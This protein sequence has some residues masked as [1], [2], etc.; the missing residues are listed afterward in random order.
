MK[1]LALITILSTTVALVCAQVTLDPNTGHYVCPAN[2][3]PVPLAFCAGE[4][5]A[6]NIIIRCDGLVGQ[7]GNCN[8]NLAGIPPVGVKLFAPCYQSSTVAGDAACS[9]DGI[10][11]P[12]S[13]TPF[14]IGSK[15]NTTT[16]SFAVV[17]SS[18]ISISISS[19]QTSEAVALSTGQI[20]TVLTNQRGTLSTPCTKYPLKSTKT[21]IPP[22]PTKKN[23][24]SSYV[25]AQFSHDVAKH[26]PNHKTKSKHILTPVSVTSGAQPSYDPEA[27]PTVP[28]IVAVERDYSRP[29]LERK[30]LS[31][32]LKRSNTTSLQG[33]T[34]GTTAG[35]GTPVQ[36]GSTP[37][38]Y[39]CGSTFKGAGAWVVGLITFV[40]T[41]LMV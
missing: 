40:L 13:G 32:L 33:T 28:V 10:A 41:A 30:G 14:Q 36:T 26:G 12:D 34:G 37:P 4:S 20:N 31:N 7:P 38:P 24:I 18:K 8:D 21:G 9:Y 5:L 35:T 39:S 11:Y 23:R 25:G 3:G 6:T 29:I 15:V 27:T 17:S 2:A 19:H 22:T 1:S 16:S